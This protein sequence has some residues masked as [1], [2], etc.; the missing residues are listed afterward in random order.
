MDQSKLGICPR[1]YSVLKFVIVLDVFI[2]PAPILWCLYCIPAEVLVLLH[3]V[4]RC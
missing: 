4:L 1:L 2:N 3:G